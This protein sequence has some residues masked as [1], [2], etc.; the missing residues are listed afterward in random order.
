MCSIEAPA[1]PSREI[2]VIVASSNLA[3]ILSP[4]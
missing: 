4:R 2:A 1:T 3:R